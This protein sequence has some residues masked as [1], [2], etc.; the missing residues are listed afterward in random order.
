MTALRKRNIDLA[1]AF[2][3]QEFDLIEG[4]MR[5][6]GIST[7]TG[8]VHVALWRFAQHLDLDPPIDVFAAAP[9]VRR[10]RSSR[11]KATPNPRV[12]MP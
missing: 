2:T 4:M 6:A 1:L 5:A 8:V 12:P 7:V 10:R 3:P 11:A 9:H